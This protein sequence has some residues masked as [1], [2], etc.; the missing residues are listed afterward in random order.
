MWFRRSV[1]SAI[2]SLGLVAPILDGPGAGPMTAPDDAKPAAH[3]DIQDLVG[4]KLGTANFFDDG[5][6]IRMEI[7]VVSLVPGAHAVHILTNGTCQG[8]SHFASAGA[9]FNPENKRHGFQN[10][11]GPHAG[12][13]C[14]IQAGPDGHASSTMLVPLASL[15]S[16]AN[17]LLPSGGTAVAIDENSDD[18]RT[19]PDGKSGAHVA[20][21]TIVKD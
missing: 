8:S 7:D 14:N 4:T 17:S 21:G 9:H 19:D 15:G 18:Y 1:L 20:C 10:P 2:L 16:G 12:D 13:L 11:D 3:A 6:T 5:G